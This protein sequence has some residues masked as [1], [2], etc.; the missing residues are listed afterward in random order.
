MDY[1]TDGYGFK[2]V[3]ATAAR[4]TQSVQS[5]IINSARRR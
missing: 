4:S 5:F 1:V 2:K 3:F